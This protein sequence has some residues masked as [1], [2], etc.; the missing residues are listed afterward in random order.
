MSKQKDMFST[1]LREKVQRGMRYKHDINTYFPRRPGST[2]PHL[3][4]KN[5]YA[6]LVRTLSFTLNVL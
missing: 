6:G 2:G 4:D 1:M 3:A 5:S